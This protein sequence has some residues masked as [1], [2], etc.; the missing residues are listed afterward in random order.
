MNLIA[1]LAPM[2]RSYLTCCKEPWTSRCHITLGV[3]KRAYLRAIVQ[4]AWPLITDTLH[5]MLSSCT[6]WAPVR[7]EPRGYGIDTRRD[8]CPEYTN[9][10]VGSIKWT[11]HYMLMPQAAGRT[12]LEAHS[13]ADA[14]AE[15]LRNTLCSTGCSNSARLGDPYDTAALREGSASIARLIQELRHL[16]CTPCTAKAHSQLTVALIG[17][18]QPLVAHECCLPGAEQ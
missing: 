1:V 13:V 18:Q 9:R 14:A 3:A 15:L 12:C 8:D 6:E 10:M 7:S 4:R 2:A 5:S 17:S 11:C 16:R